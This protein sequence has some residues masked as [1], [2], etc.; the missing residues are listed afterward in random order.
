MHDM[1]SKLQHVLPTFF[2]FKPFSLGLFPG[3]CDVCMYV[4]CFFFALIALK[5]A[6]KTSQMER[7]IVNTKQKFI[8]YTHDY[9]GEKRERE[10]EKKRGER[11]KAKMNKN[12]T[13]DGFD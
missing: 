3:I 5:I 9:D 2:L 8:K 11:E 10:K 6:S 4:D 7:S 1:C 13:L 12:I